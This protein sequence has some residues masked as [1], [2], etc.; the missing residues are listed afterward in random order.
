M[1]MSKSILE[2]PMQMLS[3]CGAEF[4]PSYTTTYT[5]TYIV[6]YCLFCCLHSPSLSSDCGICSMDWAGLFFS[7]CFSFAADPK[8]LGRQ[9]QG[10]PGCLGTRMPFCSYSYVP[11][12]IEVTICLCTYICLMIFILMA[13]LMSEGTFACWDQW[14][15]WDFFMDRVSDAKNNDNKYII[16]LYVILSI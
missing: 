13:E 7:Q 5:V 11:S 15:Q 12:C 14:N 3:K 9:P 4:L 10:K 8:V 1:P 6:Y 2:S 16:S